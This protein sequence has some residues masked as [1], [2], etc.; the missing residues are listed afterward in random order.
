MKG[1]TSMS[2]EHV[3]VE[4]VLVLPRLVFM[5]PSGSARASMMVHCTM[6]HGIFGHWTSNSRCLKLVLM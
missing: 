3:V 1:L 2:E 6:Y 4:Q 5:V